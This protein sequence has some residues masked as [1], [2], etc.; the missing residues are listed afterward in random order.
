MDN[1]LIND[2]AFTQSF[3]LPDVRLFIMKY[4]PESVEM[5]SEDFREY[6]L[7]LKALTQQHTPLYILDDSRKRGY[8]LDPEIQEWT[9]AELAPVWIGFKLRKYAQILADDLFS[10]I[11]GQQVV[12]EARKIPGMFETKF[13]DQPKDAVGWF[14]LVTEL[15]FA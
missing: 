2:T 15:S 10:K 3:Y 7:N 1:Y 13:F 4:K 12:E 14:G 6:I 11:S 5:T 9:V 8:I